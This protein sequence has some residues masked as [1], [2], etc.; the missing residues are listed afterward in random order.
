MSENLYSRHIICQGLIFFFLANTLGPVPLAQAQDFALPQP[1]TMVSLSPAF[2]PPILKG[3][4]VHPD[5]PFRFD[6]ILDRGD[7]KLSNDAL[8]SESGKLIKYFLASLTIPEKD[9]W[10]N[11]SP[12]EKNRIVPESFGQTEMGRD[13][14]AEDYMLKQITASLIYPEGEVGKRFWKRIYEEAAKKFGTTNIPVNTF[15]KVWIVPSKAVV[16]ENAKAGTA[17][18]VESKLK[19]MLEQDYLALKKNNKYSSSVMGGGISTLGS[20]IVREIIVPELTKE[21]NEG[22]NFSQL[23]QVYNSLILAMWYKKKIKDSILEQ[24]YTNKNK[25]AGVNI[26]DPQEKEKI[27]QQYLR[28]FKKGAYNYIKEEID[29]IT[30][31]TIP[32]KYFSGGVDYAMFG[33]EADRSL[34]FTSD[35][36]M[37]GAKIIPNSPTTEVVEARLD[38]SNS[39]SLGYKPSQKDVSWADLENEGYFYTVEDN[40]RDGFTKKTVSLSRKVNGQETLKSDDIIF[41]VFPEYKIVYIGRFYPDF[42][43]DKQ[44]LGRGRALLRDFFRSQSLQGYFVLTNASSSFLNSLEKMPEISPQIGEIPLLYKANENYHRFADNII[45]RLPPGPK[46]HLVNVLQGSNF[47]GR[48]AIPSYNSVNDTVLEQHYIPVVGKDG[49]MN[50]DAAMLGQPVEAPMKTPVSLS[51]KVKQIKDRLEKAGNEYELKIVVADIEKY[52]RTSNQIGNLQNGTLD[53]VLNEFNAIVNN[54]HYVIG[55]NPHAKGKRALL[56]F[57]ILGDKKIY[58]NQ[59]G[60]INFYELKLKTEDQYAIAFPRWVFSSLVSNHSLIFIDNIDSLAQ[61]Y[62]RVKRGEILLLKIDPSRSDKIEI[63]RLLDI[64]SKIIRI[65]LFDKNL[66]QISGDL[67]S[68]AYSMAFEHHRVKQMGGVPGG[69]FNKALVEKLG[70]MF[71]LYDEANPVLYLGSLVEAAAVNL[72]DQRPGAWETLYR[73]SGKDSPTGVYEWLET[74]LEIKGTSAQVRQQ[75][76]KMIR[77]DAKRYYVK[78]SG[79]EPV[80]HNGFRFIPSAQPSNP[81]AVPSSSGTEAGETGNISRAGPETGGSSGAVKAQVI[82]LSDSPIAPQPVDRF[83]PV[84]DSLRKLFENPESDNPDGINRLIRKAKERYGEDSYNDA[85]RVIAIA[86]SRVEIPISDLMAEDG[87]GATRIEGQIL[88]VMQ[89]IDRIKNLSFKAYFDTIPAVEDNIPTG[90]LIDRL[91]DD[92]RSNIASKR[93]SPEL[94]ILESSPY[95][96]NF[97]GKIEREIRTRITAIYRKIK[98]KEAGDVINI[99]EDA[100]NG[101]YD[102]LI[103]GGKRFYFR[104]FSMENIALVIAAGD[105]PTHARDMN[106]GTDFGIFLTKHDATSVKNWDDF[107]RLHRGHLQNLGSN[108]TQGLGALDAAMNGG[109]RKDIEING[110]AYE[111]QVLP[112][113]SQYY[114]SVLPKNSRAAAIAIR[115]QY[116]T[117]NEQVARNI[118]FMSS[119]GLISAIFNKLS[120]EPGQRV[121]KPQSSARSVRMLLTVEAWF[122][123][124]FPE[125]YSIRNKQAV[126]IIRQYAEA[127]PIMKDDG[128]IDIQKVRFRHRLMDVLNKFLR[129]EFI[130]GD[131]VFLLNFLSLPKEEVNAPAQNLWNPLIRVLVPDLAMAAEPSEK[132]LKDLEDRLKKD[133]TAIWG[134]LTIHD[135][136]TYYSK[137][138]VLKVIWQYLKR[139]PYEDPSKQPNQYQPLWNDKRLA[140]ELEFLVPVL[141]N[142]VDQWGGV[143]GA[144]SVADKIVDQL[145]PMRVQALRM[146]LA[147]EE[148]AFDPLKRLHAGSNY[149]FEYQEPIPGASSASIETVEGYFKGAIK[150]SG[151]IKIS[152]LV[153]GKTA[154]F[155]FSEIKAIKELRSVYGNEYVMEIYHRKDAAMLGKSTP[156]ETKPKVQ[157]RHTVLVVDNRADEINRIQRLLILDGYDVVS[158]RSGAEALIKLKENVNIN[159]VVSDYNMPRLNGLVVLEGMQK[160]E[161][162]RNIPFIF[163]TSAMNPRAS[164]SVLLTRRRE[165]LEDLYKEQKYPNYAG[166][167]GKTDDGSIINKIH[168]LLPHSDAA[169]VTKHVLTVLRLMFGSYDIQVIPGLNNH[170]RLLFPIGLSP[171]VRE[172]LIADLNMLRNDNIIKPWSLVGEN[173]IDIQIIHF[174]KEMI[175]G[176]IKARLL[177][178]GIRLEKLADNHLRLYFSRGL[179]SSEKEEARQSA[180]SLFDQYFPESKNGK[181][182]VE[183]SSEASGTVIDIR[184]SDRAMTEVSALD[185]LTA[186][187]VIMSVVQIVFIVKILRGPELNKQYD[188]DIKYLQDHD[189]LDDYNLLRFVAFWGLESSRGHAQENYK[190]LSPSKQRTLIESI[191]SLVTDRQAIGLANLPN[192]SIFLTAL[193]AKI[194]DQRPEMSLDIRMAMSFANQSLKSDRAMTTD[195]YKSGDVLWKPRPSPEEMLQNP[196]ILAAYFSSAR[197]TEEL[198]R[199]KLTILEACLQYLPQTLAP[200]ERNKR[201]NRL[202]DFFNSEKNDIYPDGNYAPFTQE[203]IHEALMDIYLRI[204]NFRYGDRAMNAVEA[205]I[206]G[207]IIKDTRI[208]K[209][210]TQGDLAEQIKIES[211]EDLSK[212]S[213]WSSEISDYERGDQLPLDVKLKQFA[214]LLDLDLSKLLMQW[215]KAQNLKVQR[216][217]FAFMMRLS[218]VNRGWTQKEVA[219]RMLIDPSDISRYE[220]YLIPSDARVLEF[221]NIYKL[222]P[223]LRDEL[224]D[225]ARKQRSGNREFALTGDHAMFTENEN[226]SGPGGIDLTSDKALAVQNNGQGIKFHID[227]AMLQQLKNAPGFVPVII[228]IQPMTNIRFFLGLNSVANDNFPKAANDNQPVRLMKAG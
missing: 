157:I 169:M 161:R 113:G 67:K 10:V 124:Q 217:S 33:N 21:V 30:Q 224:I 119:S 86:V 49:F 108:Q 145:R 192:K 163:R 83:E 120:I 179:K 183:F 176:V 170:V 202:L 215:L 104:Y 85:L 95:L 22:K 200:Q 166:I 209:G 121:A 131:R 122:T 36:A 34:Q 181:I 107:K 193:L 219:L 198:E 66:E 81:V 100:G 173:R 102:D 45:E 52:L 156:D 175:E 80:I 79:R 55:S 5:N 82:S 134:T 13:L 144:Q 31:Q 151:D 223:K 195:V 14:L 214:D 44:K 139:I 70:M 201:L 118:I 19:V 28:A 110:V 158:A 90:Q 103:G 41:D 152:I 42:P 58:Q 65:A 25:V 97:T 35:T 98:A 17:Y 204:R 159:L 112:S 39:V 186:S 101:L 189:K 114:I 38:P 6:F 109:M 226:K 11:L 129:R 199:A 92:Q 146:S 206:F 99:R 87:L 77:D 127:L 155:Y 1:G 123:Q 185:L 205:K 88:K 54:K 89:G 165:Y 142:K 106:D 115:T 227:P 111:M 210:W 149:I 2:A 218:R 63:E 57:R 125:G 73:L 84:R 221:A 61:K 40:V 164:D 15:N 208:A 180:K 130:Y 147:A 96:D 24:V 9:L 64:A 18:V 168:E 74:F 216:D 47:W 220:S 213:L 32:R 59:Y 187:L 184:M 20:Q 7:S 160:D 8:K 136:L 75:I 138:E 207:K 29:P 191:V 172:G 48:E 137:D 53:N 196:P 3:I 194:E 12:Y 222:E 126:A 76:E 27:Y 153:D 141:G 174:S 128:T 62:Q 93:K 150:E 182:K 71:A 78:L 132:E 4:K 37:L 188:S 225:A 16:Y 43:D 46:G 140:R 203:I 116:L 105:L 50:D 26:D 190:A 177:E 167:F 178:E 72:F 91:T 56:L 162:I 94:W 148:E 211:S 51:D 117:N 68:A 228:N 60:F 212:K 154:D 133:N 171:E 135:L 23:R 69:Q 197:N 143:K